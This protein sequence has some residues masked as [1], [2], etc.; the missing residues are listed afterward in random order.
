MLFYRSF[1]L[2]LILFSLDRSALAV[3]NK[4]TLIN[5]TEYERIF[6][7]SRLKVKN[8]L[9][10][11][12]IHRAKLLNNQVSIIVNQ[13]I[14]TP[15][16]GTGGTGEGDWQPN[17]L[18]YRG[19]AVHL[20]QNPVYRMDRFNCQ[21]FVQTV[22]ALL[23]SKDINEFDQRLIKISYGAAFSKDIIRYYNR[24]HFVDGDFNRINHKNGVL[25]NVTSAIAPYFVKTTNSI[26]DREQWFMEQQKKI[27][28]LITVFS[29]KNGLLMLNRLK[30]YDRYFSDFS[31]Q[32][33][34]IDYLPKNQLVMQREDGSYQ[35]NKKLFE[36]IPTPA[37]MEV[38]CDTK[39]WYENKKNIKE[40]IGTELNVSHLGILYRK[41]FKKNEFIYHKINCHFTDDRAVKICDAEPVFCQK[42][43]CPL[44]MLAHA[45]NA[46]PNGYY[47]Y[48]QDEENYV[49]TRK[50]KKDTKIFSRCN[51]LEAIPLF[52]Y[53]VD[54]QYG[55]YR[56]LDNPAVLGI[57]IE[58]IIR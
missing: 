11:L 21:T 23:F 16:D 52:D 39:K 50:L 26:I 28:P 33:L 15:Y 12:H 58:K 2:L 40:L 1:L 22:L 7:S 13:L 42:Q 20:D 6:N 17:S 45:T 43:N 57:H 37:I 55:I 29:K 24:N 48:K 10:I 3:E 36:S 44:L 14:D 46:Y 30:T 38:I 18:V 34:S 19:G 56:N 27:V 32:P 4:Y 51:R 25:K 53:L 35:E 8:I 9:N 31:H 41:V 49:C 47:W 5:K 54:E